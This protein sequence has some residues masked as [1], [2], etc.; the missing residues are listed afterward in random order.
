[1]GIS[2]LPPPDVVSAGMSPSFQSLPLGNLKLEP[3]IH[4]SNTKEA[5]TASMEPF[6]S[7]SAKSTLKFSAVFKSSVLF[8]T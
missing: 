8:K 4:F 3:F 7:T 2:P 6:P 1:M 5:S